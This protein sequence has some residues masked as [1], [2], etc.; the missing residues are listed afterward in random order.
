[1]KKKILISTGGS[2][3]HVIPATIFYEHLKDSFDVLISSD[4]RGRKFLNSKLH[5]LQIINTPKIT[6]NIFLL[7]IIFFHF[8]LLIFKSLFLF[9]K[10]KIKILLSTGGYMSLPLCIAAKILNIK[11]YLF[12]PNMVIGR[13]NKYFLRFCENIFCYSKE[14]KNYEKKY[15][16]KI[17]LIDPLLRKE[18]YSVNVEENSSIQKEINLL[19]VGGSQGAKLF[20][21]ILKNAIVSLSKN[22]KLKIFHQTNLK[23]FK[24]LREFYVKNNI[25]SE[26]FDF[27]ENFLKYIKN[28]NLCITRAGASTLSE[29]TY[30][31]I[32]Y[33]A[34]PFLFA[35]DNHQ[36]ENALYYKNKNCCWILNQDELNEDKLLKNLINIIDNKEDYMEKKKT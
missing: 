16:H 31:N 27:D 9:K 20:D 3:G 21:T 14:I 17:V 29:L 23:N 4:I 30:L 8:T 11:I 28:A 10:E 33:L 19:I 15:L 18:F 35:S 24:N 12:E 34:I 25:H 6:S 36:Y 2:G 5:N 22:Y 1:M 32:P 26:I 13:M 7:P